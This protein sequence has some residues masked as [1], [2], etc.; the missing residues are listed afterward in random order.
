MFGRKRKP[1]EERMAEAATEL[2]FAFMDFADNLTTDTFLE[3]QTVLML[4]YAENHGYEAETLTQML[5][6]RV[7]DKKEAEKQEE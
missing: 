4:V 6:N 2:T 7:H 3:I 5:E 1:I